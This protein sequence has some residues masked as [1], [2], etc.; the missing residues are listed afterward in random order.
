VVS[1]LKAVPGPESLRNKPS[2]SDNVDLARSTRP[3]VMLSV[4]PWVRMA[5][6]ARS[7]RSPRRF[8]RL[9]VTARNQRASHW[10]RGVAV[11]PH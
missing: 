1:T 11:A 5:M 6:P 9:R 10:H 3:W 8:R 4:I 2:N 7:S